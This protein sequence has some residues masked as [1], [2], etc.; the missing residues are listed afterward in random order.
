MG[1]K[2]LFILRLHA[3]GCIGWEV[4]YLHVTIDQAE[5]GMLEADRD[6]FRGN[7]SSMYDW[8]ASTAE[9]SG[10]YGK[11]LGRKKKRQDCHDE[12]GMRMADFQRSRDRS[13]QRKLSDRAIQTILTNPKRWSQPKLANFL[14]W[15]NRISHGF[16]LGRLVDVVEL[17]ALQWY[18]KIDFD[19]ILKKTPK[20]NR[21]NTFRLAGPYQKR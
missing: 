10:G 11:I 5:A 1:A 17:S 12:R 18:A 16:E 8:V 6:C 15:I 21:A 14:E 20:I 13:K 19:M 7:H 9:I 2:L 3:T 4:E